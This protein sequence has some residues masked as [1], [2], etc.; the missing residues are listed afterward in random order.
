MVLVTK[1]RLLTVI[2]IDIIPDC[3]IA[4]VAVHKV[5]AAVDV[6]FLDGVIAVEHNPVSGNI[7]HD[8]MQ[9]T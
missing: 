6:H 7:N 1:H 2:V 4:E 3:W 5:T 9:Y 8:S